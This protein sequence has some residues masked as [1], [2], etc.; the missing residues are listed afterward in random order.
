MH[1]EWR[2]KFSGG[3]W[4]GPHTHPC[5]F[6][7]SEWGPREERFLVQETSYPLGVYS[8]RMWAQEPRL[9]CPVA[10]GD[11]AESGMRGASLVSLGQG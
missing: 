10:A 3:L 6:L 5:A 8:V 9:T 1:S 4:S 11:T 7:P 2:A